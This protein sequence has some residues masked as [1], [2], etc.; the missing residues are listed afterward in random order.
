MARYLITGGTGLIGSSL[1]ESLRETPAKF[2]VLTRDPSA[3]LSKLGPTINYISNLDQLNPDTPI[4]FVVNLAGEPIA[5]KPWSTKQKLKLWQSRVELTNQLI[6]WIAKQKTPP[7]ALIS[8][9][10]IGWYGDGE[11]KILDEHSQPHQ[12]YTHNLCDAWEKAALKA[13][14]SGVRVCII[15][16]GLVLSSEGGFLKKLI[17]PFKLALGATLGSGNQYMSWIHIDDQVNAIRFLLGIDS[18]LEN[19]EPEP[20][21]T[22]NQRTGIF[23]LVAP[24]PVTNYEFTQQFASAV[25]RPAFIRVPQRLLSLG[26]GEMSRLLTTGQRVIPKHLQSLGFQ[27]KFESLASALEDVLE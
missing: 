27:F 11:D 12:E 26:L 1:I 9:S 17:L 25:N 14:A 7:K 6:T 2:F 18:P 24:S 21:N 15:R 3:A 5:D 10:A 23:N 20:T 19:A 8:G 22:I 13:V 4:D 16:T